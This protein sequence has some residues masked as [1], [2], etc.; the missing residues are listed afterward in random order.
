MKL[1]RIAL[2][3]LLLLVASVIAAC[4]GDDDDDSGDGGGSTE[5]SET[6][7]DAG[8]SIQHPSGWVAQGDNTAGYN[9]ASNQAALDAFNE[10]DVP[11][12]DALDS[13]STIVNL[14]PLPMPPGAGTAGEMFEMFAGSIGSDDTFIP[15]DPSDI[16][17]GG[18]EGVSASLEF[19]DAVSG[20]GEGQ[21][22]ILTD[23]S[24]T[25]LLALAVAAGSLDTGL[26]ESMIATVQLPEAPE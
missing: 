19:G 25:A 26:V 7:E 18:F 21:L 17:A 4:G 14:S 12:F 16:T 9:F 10:S 3:M 15:G 20:D 24:G 11:D 23:D 1:K 2:L 5:L 13:G 22:Y 8:F 6:F